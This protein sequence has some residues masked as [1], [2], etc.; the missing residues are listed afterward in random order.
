MPRLRGKAANYLFNSWMSAMRASFSHAD[1]LHFFGCDQV[2]FTLLGRLSGKKV[3]LTVDGL[4]WERKGYPPMFRKYLR[5]FAE[6]AM[7]FPN[8]TVADSKTSQSWY[9]VRTGIEPS[10]I[11]YGTSLSSGIDAAVLEKYGLKAG[12]YVLFVGRLVF[13]KGAHTVVEAFKSVKTGLKLVVVGDSLQADDY[14]RRLKESAGERIVFLGFVHGEEFTSI[15]NGALVYVH[16]SLFDGTSIA[17]LGALG[18]GVPIISSDL[19]ENMD[20]AGDAV[21]YFHGNDPADLTAKLQE[22]L[23]NPERIYQLRNSS[24]SR[25]AKLYDWD[26]ITSMYERL[27]TSDCIGKTTAGDL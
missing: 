1:V 5:S 6:L 27:Y 14:V 11:P 8:S 25:A 19:K 17:L 23:A 9:S 2:P 7:V 21:V 13:E 15:R 18:A 20:V 3:V 22:L 10:Y 12:D 26:K 16:P 24:S 4:E